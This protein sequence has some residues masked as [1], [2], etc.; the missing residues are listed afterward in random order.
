M[1]N[2]RPASD[3]IEG[4]VVRSES[5]R[6]SRLL[7]KAFAL[8]FKGLVYAQIWEDPVADMAAL[9]IGPESRVLTIAS[10]SCNALSYLTADPAAITCVDLNTAHIALGRLKIAAIENLDYADLRSFIAEADKPENAAI[11]RE[12][13]APHLDEATRRYW[14]GRDLAGRQRIRGFTRGIYKRGLLGHFIGAAHVLAKLYK[15]DPSEI[16][17]AE[18]LEEQ[19]R[20][21][22]ERFAPIFERKLVRWLADQPASLFGLGI[23]PAQYDALAG[24]HRMADVLRARLEKLACHFP[25]GDNYFAWQA[26]G[27]GYGRQ[28]KA[29]LPPYLQEANVPMVRERLGRL[30][31][32]H[33]NFTQVLSESADASFDRYILLDAQ[34]WMS[35]AQLTELWSE[36][37][38]T[39]RSGSR[40]LFRTAAEPT[41]LPGRVPEEILSRWDYRE[42]ESRAATEG[43]RSSIYGGVHLYVLKG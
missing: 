29:P 41:L 21:F 22:D 8:A 33:A 43:D 11:Y 36:I 2:A 38:R 9:Q 4:A 3:L 20:V 6:A 19:R 28:A 12:K 39:A 14:E 30:T 5:S 42:D 35:D 32:R 27:R 13:L 7:D 40:V 18:T 23:P 37:T 25:L 24:G 10:G 15:I 31:L 34:D 1:P 16:L 17:G 26:F